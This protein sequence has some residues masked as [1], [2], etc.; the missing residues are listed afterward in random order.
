MR[1]LINSRCLDVTCSCKLKASPP[2]CLAVRH[3]KSRQVALSRL[4]NSRPPHR[5]L[6]RNLEKLVAVR[7]RLTDPGFEGGVVVG[8][9]AAVRQPGCVEPID[10]A[11]FARE[12]AAYAD[13]RDAHWREFEATDLACWFEIG[14]GIDIIDNQRDVV[15][16]L[17]E[18]DD[19]GL[20]PH[21]AEPLAVCEPAR[22]VALGPSHQAF[23][24]GLRDPFAIGI[25][26]AD[27]GDGA[28]G[29]VAKLG[30]EAV[31]VFVLR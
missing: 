10:R 18:R 27:V 4:R 17:R 5:K 25:E 15:S 1:W 7:E 26:H 19:L 11:G 8:D 22:A 14:D 31:W 23:V 13:F 16:T 29:Q 20:V 28:R 24:R 21:V 3:A 30:F 2:L 12:V 9:I 6:H